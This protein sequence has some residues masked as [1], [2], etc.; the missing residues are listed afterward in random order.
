MGASP[1]GVHVCQGLAGS[2][3][4]HPVDLLAEASLIPIDNSLASRGI[5]FCRFVDDIIIFTR[6]EADARTA[7]YV[8][9]EVLDKQQRL[10]LQNIKTELLP[11]KQF[12]ERCTEMIEDMR[13]N[14]LE[15]QIVLVLSVDTPTGIHIKPSC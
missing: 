15:K 5:E 2:A 4:P 3:G 14:D 1:A 10:H 12:R 7:L 13:I 11:G 8:L 9:A 6:N